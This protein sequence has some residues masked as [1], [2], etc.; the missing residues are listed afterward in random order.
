MPYV[1]S[2]RSCASRRAAMRSARVE[3]WGSRASSAAA[4]SGAA[5]RLSPTRT[6]SRQRSIRSKSFRTAALFG[7][8]AHRP[9]WLGKD[10]QQAAAS[11]VMLLR[12][13]RPR[14]HR[15]AELDHAAM[16]QPAGVASH[17]PGRIRVHDREVTLKRTSPGLLKRRVHTQQ[18]PG[19]AVRTI[20]AALRT[21]VYR[22]RGQALALELLRTRDARLQAGVID[23]HDGL[24]RRQRATG[25]R[26]RHGPRSSGRTVRR[27]ASSTAGRPL[28]SRRTASPARP[29]VRNRSAARCTVD[30]A[31][32]SRIAI[33][34]RSLASASR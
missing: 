14:V 21:H 29:A 32:C 16:T 26:P 23:I 20:M 4:L 30:G 22:E 17:A 9:A 3:A 2:P 27:N 5:V 31:R 8:D 28:S 19:A 12:F 15:R 1:R 25:R 34:V 18:G 11:Q 24:L 10:C 13:G 6:R 7:E 33:R